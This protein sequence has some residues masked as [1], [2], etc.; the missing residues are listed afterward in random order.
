M[1][2]GKPGSGL[3]DT[4]STG[5]L[6]LDFT[7]SRTE[8]NQ[9]IPGNRTKNT[10]HCLGWGRGCGFLSPQPING[11]S[12]H[13]IEIILQNYP[14]G[15]VHQ[16]RNFRDSLE[17]QVPEY[18]RRTEFLKE[19]ITKG[20]VALRIQPTQPS[21][22]GDY[23][24]FFESSTFYNEAKFKLLVTVPG[25]APH[26]HLQ[27]GSK[28]GIKLTCRSMGWFPEPE[29]QWR[30]FQGLRLAPASETKRIEENGLFHVESSITVNTSSRADV[31][32]V[33]R[34]LILSVEKEV[35]IS[36]TDDLFP[37]DCPWAV[38][39][40]LPLSFLAI[41]IAACVLLLCSR[42][43]KGKWNLKKSGY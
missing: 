25:T 43:A 12:E 7:A 38:G 40:A 9:T 2:N 28:S 18:Q 4:R 39:F 30:D 5:A 6:T 41:G 21:D 29:V 22:G 23:T 35:H 37:K 17:Q 13:G 36:M 31:S 20:H 32:C 14:S 15:L 26:I 34:N 42:K 33:I 1:A 10:S 27:P 8:G 11:C 3:S 19:N 16:Y 24:Y